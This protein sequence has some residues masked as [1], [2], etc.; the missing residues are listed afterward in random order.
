MCDI[1]IFL[2]EGSV[3]VYFKGDDEEAKL[4]GCRA[5]LAE[6]ADGLSEKK[7]CAPLLAEMKRVSEVGGEA[8]EADRSKVVAG[9]R[10]KLK[11]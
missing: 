9:A 4:M 8:T 5:Q 7:V 11:V 1:R 6:L 2:I 10:P 3:V